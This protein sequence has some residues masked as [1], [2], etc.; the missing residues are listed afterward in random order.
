[1]SILWRRLKSDRPQPDPVCGL[2]P[3]TPGQVNGHVA[4]FLLSSRVF[5]TVNTK[6]GGTHGK[7]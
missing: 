4:V 2:R 6:F 3:R 7:S 5:G 1:M